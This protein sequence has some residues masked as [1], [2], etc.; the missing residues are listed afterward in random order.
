MSPKS[1]ELS[2]IGS[3]MV[4][5][6]CIFVVMWTINAVATILG[7]MWRKAQSLTGESD[8]HKK[9][10]TKSTQTSGAGDACISNKVLKKKET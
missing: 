10:A 3:V 5:F 2:F 4:V 1:Y 9:L 8:V 6:I 7:F